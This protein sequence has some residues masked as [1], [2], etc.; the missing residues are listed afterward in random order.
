MLDIDVVRENTGLTAT[1]VCRL[2]PSP[3][4]IEP[5]ESGLKSRIVF[6]LQLME[7]REGLI[8]F[9]GDIVLSE[10]RIYSIVQFADDF[11]AAHG[12]KYPYP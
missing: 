7:R 11:E 8:G 12:T 2:N 5:I 1:L 4:W 9:L 10:R 6:T 3:S